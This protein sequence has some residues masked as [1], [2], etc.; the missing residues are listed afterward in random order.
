MK[1]KKLKIMICGIILLFSDAMVFTSISGIA[2]DTGSSATITPSTSSIDDWVVIVE[3]IPVEWDDTN[4]DDNLRE[5]I[6]SLVVGDWVWTNLFTLEDILFDEIEV[7][8][9]VRDDIDE[10]HDAILILPWMFTDAN[11]MF[12]WEDYYTGEQL[13]NPDDMFVYPFVEAGFDV[14]CLST[15]DHNVPVEFYYDS[16]SWAE[17][18][19]WGAREYLDDIHEAVELIKIIS[20]FDRIYLNTLEIGTALG[21]MYAV[22]HEENLKGIIAISGGTGGILDK[23][24]FLPTALPPS[25]SIEDLTNVY[26][27]I[28]TDG[29]WYGTGAALMDFIHNYYHDAFMYPDS[30]DIVNNPFGEMSLWLMLGYFTN[31]AGTGDPAFWEFML[32]YILE[33]PLEPGTLSAGTKINAVELYISF[34]G[35]SLLIPGYSLEAKDWLGT[36]NIVHPFYPWKVLIDIQHMSQVEDSSYL[37]EL[38]GIDWDQHFCEINIPILTFI[39]TLT[40]NWWDQADYSDDTRN[41]DNTIYLVENMGVLDLIL[42]PI[43]EELIS[44]PSIEWMLERHVCKGEMYIDGEAI[45][46]VMFINNEHIYVVNLNTDEYIIFEVVIVNNEQPDKIYYEA[47]DEIYG[48]IYGGIFTNGKVEFSGES[49]I[50]SGVESIWR[51]TPQGENIEVSLEFNVVITFSEVISRGTTTLT[52]SDEGPPPTIGLQLYSSQYYEITTTATYSGPITICINYDD[53]DLTPEQ[54]NEL[55]LMHYDEELAQW[56]VI[57]TVLNTELNKIY[58]ETNLLS[59]FGLM[60]DITPPE[61]SVSGKPIV[62]WPPNH[63]YHIIEISDF[64]LS[65]NDLVDLDCGIED[66]VI[67]SVSS[68]EP[69]N[70]KGMGDSNT[71][72]DIVIVNSQTVKLRAERQGKGN[73]RVYTI[74]F[75]VKDASGNTVHSSFKV[76]VPHNKKS[77]SITIDDGVSAGYIVY[78]CSQ[79]QRYLAK[80]EITGIEILIN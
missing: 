63:E 48:D 64:V 33:L 24:P 68:D 54:E 65:V 74:N 35:S 18:M 57:T 37:L 50:F 49:F 4:I 60:Y 19:R 70:I 39:D 41:P 25:I 34:L 69:E 7:R 14:Y 58:G 10:Y 27:F 9:L 12:H 46:A 38:Y 72:N 76:W 15:R 1:K 51:N 17:M 66:V 36:M 26:E 2:V 21:M 67:T 77:G 30:E 8:R 78:P 6:Y 16:A 75:E 42:S 44:D 22:E 43:R 13:N 31:F 3:D 11:A 28:E 79:L 53:S 32:L 71:L 5:S 55:Q 52:M 62:L 73:G 29:P 23:E 80:G 56:V 59:L 40:I 20:G 47:T 45:P 61:V